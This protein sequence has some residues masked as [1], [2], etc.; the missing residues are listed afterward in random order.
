MQSLPP[1]SQP[2]P[3]QPLGLAAVAPAPARAALPAP[4]PQ[5]TLATGAALVRTSTVPL[6]LAYAA[7][8]VYASVYPFEGWR[9]QGVLPWDWWQAPLPRYWTWFDVLGNVL[10]YAPLGALGVLA[11]LRTGRLARPRLLA[12]AVATVALGALSFALESAQTYLPTRYPSNL[13][14]A[15]NTLGALVGGAGAWA[16]ERAGWLERWELFRARWLV[17]DTRGA[18]V[19]LAL[20]PFALLFP[21]AVP[22][23]LGQVAERLELWLA[24]LLTG[25]PWLEW[26]PVRE[27]ELQPLLPL[28]E[29]AC[30]ACGLVAPCLLGYSMLRERWQRLALCALLTAIAIAVSALSAALSFGPEEAMAWASAPVVAG[31][32]VGVAVAV[33]LYAL[34]RPACLVAALLA[35]G[36]GLALL[37]QAPEG[38]YF[39][40]TLQTWEQGR[41]VR[42][43]GLAQWLGWVWPY[44]AMLYGLL[45]LLRGRFEK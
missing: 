31:V 42:L 21:A 12:V 22:L 4:A 25:T 27:V 44:A 20:W 24:E 34:P 45:R 37:N 6:A 36:L 7:L 35:W 1:D 11:L 38:P 23:G 15:L 30:V 13:D 10:G 14:W 29:V 16:L 26:L 28:A 43:N 17:G 41:F 2:P 5:A 19:L 32:M 40:Q 33:L 3:S 8:L 18:L 39:A 9:D